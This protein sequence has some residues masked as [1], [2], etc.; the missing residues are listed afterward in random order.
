ME[1][2]LRE[3]KNLPNIIGSFIYVNNLG[4]ACTDLP[5]IFQSDGLE[6]IG[7][8]LDRIFQ[9]NKIAG[10]D[11]SSVE[12]NFD[13][14]LIFVKQVDE[15][16]SLITVCDPNANL[17]LVNMSAKMLT[18]ELKNKIEAARHGK[19]VEESPPPRT[20]S[21]RPSADQ[22]SGLTGIDPTDIEQLSLNEHPEP[23][24]LPVETES[25]PNAEQL[26][27][28]GSLA[29]ILRQLQEALIKVIGPFGG[30]VMHDSLEKWTQDGPCDTSRL[31]ELADMLC[32]EI[33]H[34]KL[35]KEFRLAVNGLLL[36]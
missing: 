6:R 21:T 9:L 11:A 1:E 24:E 13:E 29:D 20:D 15:G 26:L 30:I 16:A 3:I 25:P 28:E 23:P 12:I 36:K 35:E 7:R 31:P 4:I 32:L 8:S 2:Q 5:R 18:P 34:E 14:S 19:T 17:A 27:S 22:E 10:I 33:D